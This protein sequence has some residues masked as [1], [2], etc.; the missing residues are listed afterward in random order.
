MGVRVRRIAPV[1]AV[2]AVLATGCM[3]GPT[4]DDE[5]PKPAAAGPTGNPPDLPD[6]NPTDGSTPAAPP[7]SGAPPPS[8]RTGQKKQTHT[9]S[10]GLT[11]TALAPAV[12]RTA[13]VPGERRE[14]VDVAI[15]IRYGNRTGSNLVADLFQVTL[16]AGPD[17]L[18]CALAKVGPP[19][20]GP[21]EA[22]VNAD[23]VITYNFAV[24]RELV[25]KLEVQ[26]QPYMGRLDRVT[27]ATSAALPA[28]APTRPAEGPSTQPS[29]VVVPRSAPT[30]TGTS[31]APSGG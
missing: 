25:G 12:T 15:P 27:F 19:R 22:A 13:A 14:T 29:T 30:G 21:S 28:G 1:C 5:K 16:Y 3:V 10:N 31:A 17:A 2:V 7:P 20:G 11:V 26:V 9:Y 8:D 23:T 4:I 24:P 6:K 18:P